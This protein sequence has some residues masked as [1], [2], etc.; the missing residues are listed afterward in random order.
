[1]KTYEEQASA[2]AKEA[3]SIEGEIRSLQ[4]QQTNLKNQI[5]LKEAER[6]QL[7]IEIEAITKRINDNSEMVGYTVAQF[8]YNDEVSTIER[9]A[10]ADS[11]SSFIDE[12]MQLSTMSDTLVD[13]IKENKNLKA[14]LETKK[15]NAESILKDLEAQRRLIYS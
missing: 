8:Y 3:D 14:D 13:I 15:A 1:M 5:D 9:I 2:Y 6:E 11:F 12:E 7:I 4:A 10:S